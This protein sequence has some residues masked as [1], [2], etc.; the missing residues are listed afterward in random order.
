MNP[1]LLLIPDRYK[2]DKL[3][4]QIPDS[5]AGDLTFA[6]NSNATRVNSAGLIEKVRT[7]LALQSEDYTNAS[8]AKA[9]NATATANSTAA[10]NGTNTADTY[11][12]STAITTFPNIS[13]DVSA[14][15]GVS[16]TFSIYAKKNVTNFI[17]LRFGGTAFATSTNS[18]IFN[19]NTGAILSGTGKIEN[20]GNGWYRCSITEVAVASA[21]GGFALDL[22]D[23]TGVW[24]ALSVYTASDSVFVW[25]GQLEVS[26][27]GATP[28][29]PTTTAAVSV[30]ITANIPRLDY[31]GGG[32]P[33]LL[34]ESQ[35][36]NLVTF[37]EQFDNAAY[38]KNNLT[39]TANDT[40]S[41]E[42][43]QNADK[44]VENTSNAQHGVRVVIPS[45][46]DP[47]SFSVFAKSLSGNR[48][49]QLRMAN[50]ISGSIVA[51]FDLD[52]GTIIINTTLYGGGYTASPSKIISLGNGWYKCTISGNKTDN[53]GNNNIE[54]NLSS[55][56][57]PAE[58]YSYTGN[59][60]SGV[61]V[62][63]A[64][65]EAGSYPTSYIPTLGSSV[66][67]LA[68]AAFKTGIS[69]LIGGGVG[70]WFMDFEMV[71]GTGT[72]NP[73]AFDLS[74]GTTSNR[75]YLYWNETLQSWYWGGGDTGITLPS[76][77][78]KK[79]AVKFSGTTAKLFCNGISIGTNTISTAFTRLDIGQRFSNTFPMDGKIN[80][81]YFLTTSLTDAQ[82]IS[83][84]T[85]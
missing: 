64:Q 81:A 24:S 4:S 11:G 58:V 72:G 34:L 85:I 7:N 1:S 82:C 75:L 71:E 78:R 35:R 20:I 3:Y 79:V 23:S 6:R 80:Q 40:I 10:P 37:S 42:G 9:N 33:S 45:S 50:D 51:L 59:G 55:T 41:P 46:I 60:T 84:T 30:G 27:F 61:F 32:C 77:L 70:T 56:T 62:Y 54:I 18:P 69:S 26:D 38:T 5:G 29:I 47:F 57:T 31:T 28:Y 44:L 36:T 65:L 17:K 67:R 53:V 66:T 43:Y 39:V 76:T 15:N 8:W 83:L 13:Q 12:L 22:P 21:S 14:T 68:D 16:Y 63:G 2:A 74:D 48:Y 19:L 49:L 52:N 73:F 25:G